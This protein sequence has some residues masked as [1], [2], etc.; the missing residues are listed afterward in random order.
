MNLESE[1]QVH[2]AQVAKEMAKHGRGI[3]GDLAGFDMQEKEPTPEEPIAPIAPN[4]FDMLGNLIPSQDEAKAFVANMTDEQKLYFPGLRKL[5]IKDI[6]TLARLIGENI[7]PLKESL[8]ELMTPGEVN[9]DGEGRKVDVAQMI[10]MITD[11]APAFIKGFYEGILLDLV[12]MND[13]QFQDVALDAIPV[14]INLIVSQNDLVGFYKSA[15]K[16]LSQRTK[17]TASTAPL[18]LI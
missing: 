2:A 12:G 13:E 5:K 8:T 18:S 3:S 6:G 7:T 16:Y 1:V 11:L 4:D 15:M 14:L 17:T 10:E 9:E